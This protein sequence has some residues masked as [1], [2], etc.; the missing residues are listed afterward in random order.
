MRLDRYE[1]HWY[2]WVPP[3]VHDPAEAQGIFGFNPGCTFFFNRHRCRWESD[4]DLVQELLGEGSPKMRVD[5]ETAEEVAA[6]F[7]TTLP[8]LSKGYPPRA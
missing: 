2:V 5:R 6:R 8:D 4:A 7:G 1:V 3:G